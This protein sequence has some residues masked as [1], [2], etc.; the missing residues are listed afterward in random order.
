MLSAD[1]DCSEVLLLLLLTTR[2]VNEFLA[3]RSTAV[4][5]LRCESVPS[6][7]TSAAPAGLNAV[8]QPLRGP[9]V[10]HAGC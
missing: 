7:G 5:A 1:A 8:P 6:G 9:V 10:R 4:N 2:S 3:V